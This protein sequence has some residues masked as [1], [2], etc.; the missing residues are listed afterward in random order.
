MST[1]RKTLSIYWQHT[2]R[3]RWLFAAGTSGAAAAVIVQDIVPPFIVA[4]AFNTLQ[5]VYSSGGQLKF[6]ELSGY[7][8]AYLIFMLGGVILW[9]A[10][11]I[12][13][14][15]Y[16]MKVLRDIANRVF[17]FLQHQS[18]R[19]HANHFAGALVTQANR[20]INSYESLMDSFIWDI[21]SGATTLV[22][23]IIFLLFV[24]KVYSLILL[25]ISLV[26]L[27]IIYHRARGQIPYNRRESAR[28][29]DQTAALADVITNVGTVSTFAAEKREYQRFAKVTEAKYSAS[30][31]LMVYGMKTEIMS[32]FMT[33]SINIT[34]LVTGVLAITTFHARVSVLV[35]A[36]SYT[37][38]ITGRL[39]QF[40]RV[41]RNINKALGD[42]AEMTEMLQQE[43]EIKEPASPKKL[44][45]EN[46][47]INFDHVEF[48]YADGQG[49]VVLPDL[50]LSVP[51][52]KK[53]GLVGHSGGGKTTITKLVLRLMDI[54][55]GSLTIDGTDIREV[56]LADLR[57]K[58][59]YVPQEPLLFHRAISENI[60]Y[61]KPD[62]SM[63]EIVQAAKMA[64]AHEFIK[65]LP[66]GYDTLVG[67]R[68]IKLSGGQRQRVAI[69]RAMLKNAPILVLDEATSALDSESE[70]LIQAALWKLMQYRTAIVIAHRLSTVQRMDQ[71]AV[72]E[73]G[74]IVE[75]GSHKELLAQGGIYATL[76]KHQSGGFLED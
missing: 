49:Q 37:Q 1:T 69:A 52:G 55:K 62:A 32:H 53:V 24:S 25:A 47:S 9:R 59:A 58:I 5:S 13:V 39:W 15:L 65:D 50:S 44:R 3:Y 30:H 60:G 43:P 57:S 11:V 12:C 74:K 45:I 31:A 54:Q 46:G 36:V 29:S 68:G 48:G 76:W 35:L 73:D 20:F 19:F 33:A 34:A 14:W 40:G 6:S 23:S 70:K 75:Q 67:E 17:D 22:A 56:A 8:I 66:D 10:Q 18:Y 51:G 26:Y 16:E 61:A 38:G 72:L 71:I 41:V 64:Y 21:T 4:K 28:Q 27:S 63:A 42:A 2:L 7:L